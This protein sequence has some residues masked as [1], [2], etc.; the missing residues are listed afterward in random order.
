MRD[1]GMAVSSTPD[2][3][4]RYATWIVHQ[5]N[6]PGDCSDVTFTY[7]LRSLDSFRCTLPGPWP[8]TSSET[9]VDRHT[10]ETFTSMVTVSSCVSP[11]NEPCQKNCRLAVGRHQTIIQPGGLWETFSNVE[12]RAGCR[13]ETTTQ[14]SIGPLTRQGD[15]ACLNTLT[16]CN[17]FVE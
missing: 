9:C 6:H 17:R 11:Q 14:T 13:T 10:R 7:R 5:D 8:Y 4:I 12:T 15:V 16:R 3:L 1:I 2:D